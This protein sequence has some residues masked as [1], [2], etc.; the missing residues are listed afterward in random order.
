MT[1]LHGDL[2]RDGCYCCFILWKR[3]FCSIFILFFWN[4][5]ICL[6]VKY[7]AKIGLYG[8]SNPSFSSRRRQRW[9]ER[10]I[11]REKSWMID[12]QCTLY[13]AYIAFIMNVTWL[14]Q[15]W[16]GKNV[17]SYVS[18]FFLPKNT[19]LA[20]IH[21]FQKS[22]SRGDHDLIALIPMYVHCSHSLCT[23]ICCSSNASSWLF[24]TWLLTKAISTQSDG[25]L[26]QSS[27]WLTTLCAS[28]FWI[29]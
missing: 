15:K 4:C 10:T 17:L 7:M 5:E 12:V 29:L 11:G 22:I 14:H 27:N 9:E 16:S 26:Y 19:F 1:D 25:K 18:V 21:D 3:S 28:F 13:N 24:G 6:S 20:K 23:I 2:T 8:L